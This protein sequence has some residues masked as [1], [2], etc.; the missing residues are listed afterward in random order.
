MRLRIFVVSIQPDFRCKKMPAS[1]RTCSKMS[2]KMLHIILIKQKTYQMC[3]KITF[4]WNQTKN[5]I[6]FKSFHIDRYSKM[7]QQ[8]I[9]IWPNNKSFLQSLK[10]KNYKTKLKLRPKMRLNCTNLNYFCR[11]L[12]KCLWLPAC[13]I[14]IIASHNWNS[15]TR[16]LD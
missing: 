16:N 14:K 13:D 4:F 2:L 1:D 10:I 15:Q 8:C 11:T 9:S 6:V 3:K 5:V 7:C 12:L